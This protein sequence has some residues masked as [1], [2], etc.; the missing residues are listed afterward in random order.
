MLGEFALFGVG[1]GSWPELFPR[2][3][4]PPWSSLFYREA[5]ND[6]LE[7]LAETGLVGFGLLA[8]FFWQGGRRLYQSLWTVSRRTVSVFA[9]LVA[10]L[11]IMAFHEFFD[12]NLQIPANAF[13]FTLLLGTAL[14]L[15]GNEGMQGHGDAETI[16]LLPSRR[17]AVLPLRHVGVAAGT[18]VMALLLLLFA[19]MQESLPYPYNVRESPSLAEAREELFSHPAR[20]SSHLSLF[21][22]LQ[23]SGVP[24]E[25]L[26]ELEIALWLDPRNPS[27]RDLYATNLL[28]QR[29][30]EEGLRELSQSVTFAPDLSAHVYSNLQWLPSLSAKEQQAVE[31]GFKQALAAG[32]EGAVDSLGAFYTALDRFA[33]VGRVYEEAA[34]QE[35]EAEVQ[36][37]DLVNAGLAYARAGGR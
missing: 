7:L 9:A 36:V 8:W 23:E 19:F 13:L 2:Y 5:H 20:S 17:I 34:R 30:T 14:R 6:Y 24:A 26:R 29:R 16:A 33:E 12:F 35:G 22:A 32:Y 15:A 1:L 37:R 18:G 21:R 28:Q 11:G 3:Q 25:L 10:A 31:E 27:V 4:T